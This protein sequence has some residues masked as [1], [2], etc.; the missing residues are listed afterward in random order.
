[1]NRRDI[2]LW[3]L[4]LTILLCIG[5]LVWA[6]I[7]AKKVK[8]ENQGDKILQYTLAI[9]LSPLYVLLYYVTK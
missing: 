3:G 2:I 1:M 6:I 5:F 8:T 7:L 4:I 9:F